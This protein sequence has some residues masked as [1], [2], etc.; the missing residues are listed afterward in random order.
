MG[1]GGA[2][3]LTGVTAIAG[4]GSHSV[5]L[6]SDGTV[7]AWGYGGLGQLGDG[8][9][10]NWTIPVQVRGPGNIGYLTGVAAI[11]VGYD[12]TLALKSDG[13]FWAWGSGG[14]GQLG[15]G[16]RTNRSN[17]V[18]VLGAGGTGYLTGVT[19]FAGGGSHT[20][21]LRTNGTVWAWG[22]NVHGQLG[23]GSN[24]SEPLPVGV[25]N[26]SGVAGVTAIAGGDSHT[27]AL[28][29]NGTVWDW[30]YNN[31]GQLGDGTTTNRTSAVQVSGLSGVTAIAGGRNHAVALKT[32]GTVWTWGYNYY[33]QLGDGTSTNRTTPVQVSGLT[34]VTAVAAGDYH[35][36]ALRVD[37]TVWAWGYNFF[38]QL[39]DGTNT[40]RS[41]PVQVWGPGGIGFLTGVT[42]IEA[43]YGHSV[44]LKND[45]GVL[46]WGYNA[47]GQLGDGTTTQRTSPV[48]VIVLSGATSIAAGYGYTAAL[49]SDGTVW[50]WGRNNS[51]QLG[52]GTTSNRSTPG[53]VLGPGG[54]GYLTGVTAVVT[55]GAHSAALKSDGM[56]WTWGY[57]VNGQ[58]GDGTTTQRSTPV[59]VSGLETASPTGTVSING[60]DP[61]ATATE[62]M[63]TLSAAVGGGSVTQMRIS[64]DGFFDSEPL[65]DFAT[66]KIWVLPSG[67]GTKT[68]YVRFRSSL[69]T[70][71]ETVSDAITLD[72]TAPTVYSVIVSPSMAAANDLLHVL[73]Y[74]TDQSGV[75]SVTADGVPLVHTVGLAWEGNVTGSPALGVHSVSV[76]ASDVP[77]N[78]TGASG[79]YR[80]AAILGCAGRCI[81]EPVVAAACSSRLVKVWG[82]VTIIDADSFYL[83]DGSGAP[84]KIVAPGYTGIADGDHA[85]AR[86]ILELN[87]GPR[88]LSCRPEHIVHYH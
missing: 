19:A 87:A 16:Y 17:P 59:Q 49:K 86:G 81:A 68:V 8:T 62:V 85:S 66:S 14:L 11:A 74:A 1:P 75:A 52:D 45:G 60:G 13:T 69:G 72:T 43:G 30:G 3:Y 26:I 51:G 4:G 83:D 82:K 53:Q 36:V 28:K 79:S 77:G 39:G 32:D 9:N 20:V 64:N 65:E 55:G 21:A 80:T 25:S 31:Y 54:A 40:W 44:A 6:R 22:Y 50:T 47:Y 15:D 27:L 24:I 35:T 78:S 84:V 56:V 48:T 7:W 34:G 70:E 10:N 18:Q 12:H 37:G 73:V 57:N 61:Y 63:L 71:S 46:T 2:G 76:S 88:F 23:N 67:D 33:G 5:A 38:G 29:S 42:A 41:T 58:L